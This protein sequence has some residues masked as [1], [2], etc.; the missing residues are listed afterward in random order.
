MG[1]LHGVYLPH[2]PGAYGHDLA[3]NFGLGIESSDVNPRRIYR[4]LLRAREAGFD[5]AHLWLCEAGEG[6]VTEGDTVAGVHP[7]LVESV[8]IIQECA[9]LCG[10]RIY[11][12]L[13]DGHS[14]SRVGE[15]LSREIFALTD[16]TAQFAERVAASLIRRLDPQLTVAVEIINEPEALVAQGMEWE[17][18]CAAMETIAAAIEA[19]RGGTLVTAGSSL[20]A[21]PY[22]WGSR[23][24]S[25][26]DLHA[27]ADS[28]L[29]G[30]SRVATE[31]A[32]SLPR[33][34]PLLSGCCREIDVAH[35][36]IQ[37]DYDAL[38]VAGVAERL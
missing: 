36:P 13:L 1:P 33:S 10:L 30:R 20:D 28:R 12:S 11:C 16:K 38:F 32:R 37:D 27:D 2:W 14:A 31:L 34:M 18:V 19:E 5:A 22:F 26:V 25:A 9:S 3:P 35:Q 23:W 15:K 6:I 24:L 4:P 8:A 21:L 7:A 29:P 17:G